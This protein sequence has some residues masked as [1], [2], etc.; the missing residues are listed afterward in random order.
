MSALSGKRILMTRPEKQGEALTQAITALGGDVMH[1]PSLIITPIAVPKAKQPFSDQSIAIFVSANAVNQ[2]AAGWGDFFCTYL[3][4]CEVIA[5]G[6]ATYAELKAR[7]LRDIIVPNEAY[8]SEGI[9]AL[10]ILQQLTSTPVYLF[11]GEGGRELLKESLLA[12]GA[13]LH[14]VDC[15]TRHMPSD[16][17]HYLQSEWRQKH[18]DVILIFSG[19]SLENLCK[20]L[21]NSWQ[22]LQAMPLLVISQRL[23]TIARRLGFQGNIIVA[24]NASQTAIINALK[25]L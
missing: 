11:K 22:W 10:P 14:E 3:S 1:Y 17:A 12:R 9:L 5:I 15:Y 19:E 13:L 7:G 23:K 20:M 2:L 25:T 24:R 16:Y 8:H 6:P 21:D 18:I 4:A